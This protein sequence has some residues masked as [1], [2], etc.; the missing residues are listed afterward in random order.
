MS[1]SIQA[2][3]ALSLHRIDSQATTVSQPSNTTTTTSS[4]KARKEASIQLSV[5]LAQG[6]LYSAK[7][8]Y[9]TIKKNAPASLSDPNNQTPK[10]VAFKALGKALESGDLHSARQAFSEFNSASSQDIPINTNSDPQQ[11]LKTSTTASTHEGQ[12]HIIV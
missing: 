12:L 10:A 4:F 6:D 3:S 2:I 11:K 5:S 8:A 7:E 1:T 9:D